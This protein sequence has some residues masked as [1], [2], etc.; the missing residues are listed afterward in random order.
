[1]SIDSDLLSEFVDITLEKRAIEKRKRELNQRQRE[2]QESILQQFEE[3][4]QL[5]AVQIKGYKV[6]PR[7]ELWASAIDGDFERACD[8][9]RDSG[10]P[11]YIQTRFDS[12]SVSALIRE[13]DAEGEIPQELLDNLKISE[14]FKLSV[15]K[16]AA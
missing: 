10:H 3:N 5:D 2:L 9:L 6:S 14:T 7:R 4:E 11:E 1:M 8:A 15:T 12:R 13:Y 16:G